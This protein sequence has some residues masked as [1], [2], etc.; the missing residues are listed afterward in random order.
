MKTMTIIEAVEIAKQNPNAV[1]VEVEGGDHWD[2]S[3]L[4]EAHNNGEIGENG[5]IPGNRDVVFYENRAAME[6]DMETWD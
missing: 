6:A 4:T 2:A 1:F 5:S 3:C